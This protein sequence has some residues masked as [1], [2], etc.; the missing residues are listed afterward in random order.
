MRGARIGAAAGSV[1]LAVT[2]LVALAG[3]AGASPQFSVA[4]ELP[5]P[6]GT[7]QGAA[8]YES[9]SCPAANDC[10]AVGVSNASG[11]PFVVTESSGTWGA[12]SAVTLPSGA[13]SGA[14]SISCPSAGSCLVA[15]SFVDAGAGVPFLVEETSGTWGAVEQVTPPGDARTGAAEEADVAQPWCASAGNCEAVGAYESTTS[16]N[17]M[18]AT[19]TGGSWSAWST[20]SSGAPDPVIQPGSAVELHFTC[21][22]LGNCVALTGSAGTWT[23]ADGTWSAGTP[24]PAPP[25]LEGVASSFGATGVACPSATTCVAVGEL[26]FEAC[27]PPEP[28]F[29]TELAGAAVETAGTWAAPEVVEG[30]NWA[31]DGISCID[32]SCLAVGSSSSGPDASPTFSDPIAATWADGSWSPAVTEPVPL[33][34]ASTNTSVSSLSA[35]S[36]SAAA[37]C[38]AVGELREMTPQGGPLPVSPFDSVIAPVSAAVEPGRPTN[39]LAVPSLGGA[40]VSWS[41]PRDDGG[42]PIS[43]YTATVLNATGGPNSCTTTTLDCSLSGLV[44]GHQY[45]VSVTANNG[46]DTSMPARSNNF[47]AGAAPTPPGTVRVVRSPNGLRV[48]WRPS[49]APSGERVLRYEVTATSGANDVSCLTGASGTSCTLLVSKSVSWRISVIA[50]DLSGWS[51]P[52]HATYRP[53]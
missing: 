25:V 16:W 6:A 24:T 11:Q 38:V 37:S 46:T 36:C 29:P 22:S 19:E 17:L 28:C 51:P 8:T 33:T 18:S 21:S 49:S 39:L 14:L 13:S 4:Q 5:V 10:A 41:P 44:N 7:F 2:S 15:G 9:I 32:G 20:F 12:P 26:T 50:D 42:E 47:F 1:A 23:Q 30:P 3:V 34:G 43:T 45:V 31:F 40:S 52:S 35:V 48:T 27:S 53:R